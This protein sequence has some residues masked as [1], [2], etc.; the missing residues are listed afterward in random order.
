MEKARM[1]ERS[2]PHFM[3]YSATNLAFG[4]AWRNMVMAPPRQELKHLMKLGI[5]KSELT[6]ALDFDLSLALLLGP[7]IYWHVFLRRTSRNPRNLAEGVVDAFWRAFGVT[8]EG[9]QPACT[10]STG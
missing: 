3:A 7:L 9:G 10:V 4:W 5:E 6:P 1:R 8:Q 2:M